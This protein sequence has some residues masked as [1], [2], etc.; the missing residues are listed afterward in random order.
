MAGR[1]LRGA[2]RRRTQ[3]AL[4]HAIVFSTWKSLVREQ[5]LNQADAVAR[6]MGTSPSMVIP[7]VTS[8]RKGL[9]TAGFAS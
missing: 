6:A 5:G 2:A 4:G 1:K 3:A 8:T 7:P 9:C